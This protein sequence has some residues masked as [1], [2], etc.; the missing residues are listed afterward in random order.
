MEGYNDAVHII[1]HNI[2]IEFGEIYFEFKLIHAHCDIGL[3][4]MPLFST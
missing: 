4:H 2:S 1:G 3:V